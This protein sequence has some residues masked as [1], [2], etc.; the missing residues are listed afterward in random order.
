MDDAAAQRGVAAATAIAVEHGLDVSDAVVLHRSNRIAVHL[1]PGD[2]LARVGPPSWEAALR[3]AV[4]VAHRL[5]ATDAPVATPHP[6][7]EPTVH[8]RDELA[9]TIWTYYEP[10]APLAI[11]P[12]EYAAALARFHAGLRSIDVEGAPRF[13]DRVADALRALEDH[14]DTPELTDDDRT[15]LVTTLRAT[16]A[17]IDERTT[18]RQQLLHGEPHLGNLLRTTDGLLLIDLE[19]CCHGPVDFDVAH[20]LL[21]DDD[22]VALDTEA[23][24]TAYP[25]VDPEVVQRAKALIWAMITTWRWQHGD[26]LPGRDR[27]RV[28][29]LDRLRRALDELEPLRDDALPPEREGV[30][31]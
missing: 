22:G 24:C 8:V 19:T 17:E 15:L 16:S 11:E 20:G 30:A 23:V 25:G 28:E 2:V 14:V 13:T 4:D 12:G 18:D 5:T 3:H 29:G 21:P 6:A 31:R 27:W 1:G 9:V 10:R 7:V 26:R